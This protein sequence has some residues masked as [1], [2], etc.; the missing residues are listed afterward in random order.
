MS[1]NQLMPY[2]VENIKT[3]AVEICKSKLFPT[4]T[5]PEAT[6]TLM[7]LCQSEGLHPME[8]VKQ[9]D[10]IAGRVAMKS[11]T[12]Q[13]KFQE[14]GGKWQWLETTERVARAKATWNGIETE[15]SYS[16]EQATKMGLTVK[17][18]WKK[19]PEVM[20]R[21]R[22][23]SS[24]I[25]MVAPEINLGVYTPEEVLEFS[26][27]EEVKEVKPQL[28]APEPTP[29]P[30]TQPE[31][32]PSNVPDYDEKKEL[33][34]QL[35]MLFD[36]Y[37]PKEL[38][39]TAEQKKDVRIRFTNTFNTFKSHP[40][41]SF[42]EILTNDMRRFLLDKMRKADNKETFIEFVNGYMQELEQQKAK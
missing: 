23:I 39:L 5:T 10:I 34:K 29:Q 24:G 6:F 12:M 14:A 38:S 9:Y 20:L 28:S 15:L 42:T 32:M 8:A 37:I 13:A 36:S 35:A 31:P 7:M 40:I 19:Q 21:K 11:D 22:L 26:P 2:S 30:A 4:C 33:N 41:K 17:D 25:R 3:L 18:N 27:Y 1:N 16:F